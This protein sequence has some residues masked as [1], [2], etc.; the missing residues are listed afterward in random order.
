LAYDALGAATAE[1]ARVSDELEF[2]VLGPLEVSRAGEPVALGGRRER[3]LLG[4]LLL[5]R[6]RAVERNAIVDA[7]WG[8]VAPTTAVNALQVAVHGL[9]KALGRERLLTQGSAYRCVVHEGELD[10]ARFEQLV[11]DAAR[12]PPR[13]AADLLREAVALHRGALLADL[14]A[15]PF[16]APERR[17]V[18]ELRLDALERRIDADLELGRHAEVVGEL[19]ALVAEHRSGS[20]SARS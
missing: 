10:L 7:L 3:A 20:G 6:G 9:R 16:V 4:V 18:D 14:D 2:R 8:E 1:N 15:A 13:R 12:E 11:A 17:R 19:E 5:N